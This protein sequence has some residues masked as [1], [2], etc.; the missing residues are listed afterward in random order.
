MQ[1]MKSLGSV[2]FIVMS[3]NKTQF[4]FVAV[5]FELESFFWKVH[6]LMEFHVL[7]AWLYGV[8][9]FLLDCN[10]YINKIIFGCKYFEF[11]LSSIVLASSI[12]LTLAVQLLS[13]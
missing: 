1:K 5:N 8:S 9:Y 11:S 4:T 13:S 6:N 12:P 2:L 7:L 3:I 10:I